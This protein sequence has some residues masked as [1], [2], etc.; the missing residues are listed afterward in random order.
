MTIAITKI[1]AVHR[2][3]KTDGNGIATPRTRMPSGT[4]NGRRSSG[5]VMRRRITASCA[6][7]NASS[8]PKLKRLARNVTERVNDV[9]TMSRIAIVP[10]A[11]TDAG[12]TSVR[13]LSRPKTA[14]SWPCSPS[15]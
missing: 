15:E 4:R 10:A 14:G 9:P 3:P 12:E 8:T 1:A 11:T 13:R 5:F 6:A 2:A 7:V